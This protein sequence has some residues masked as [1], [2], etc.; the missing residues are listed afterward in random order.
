MSQ[1]G[2]KLGPHF[3]ASLN[4]PHPLYCQETP[5]S[6]ASGLLGVVTRGFRE[7]GRSRPLGVPSLAVLSLALMVPAVK[8]QTVIIFAGGSIGATGRI[9][10][11]N[12]LVGGLIHLSLGRC[13]CAC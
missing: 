13:G 9:T 6:E 11:E 2:R 10:P 7:V 3:V 12:P 8:A 4:H 5:A 1:P